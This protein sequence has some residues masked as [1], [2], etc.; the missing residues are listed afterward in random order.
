M[1][2]HKLCSIKCRASALAVSAVLLITNMPLPAIAEAYPSD[3]KEI[4][5]FEELSK[6]IS[7]Q[8]VSLG[9]SIEDLNLP[10]TIGAVIQFDLEESKPEES[11]SEESKPE[12]SQTE[13][14]KPEEGQTEESKP[15][16]SQ[17]EES[18]PEEG[19]TEES[20]TEESQTE[21]SKPEEGQNEENKSE[22]SQPEESLAEESQPEEN[23]TENYL[24]ADNGNIFTAFQNNVSSSRYTVFSREESF[25]QLSATSSNAVF[26]EENA[27]N[28]VIDSTDGNDSPTTGESIIAVPVTWEA[29]PSYDSDTVGTYIFTAVLP[30]D[31][32]VAAGVTMPEITVTVSDGDTL[33][34]TQTVDNIEITLT[35]LAG[36][37]PADAVLRVEKIVETEKVAQIESAIQSELDASAPALMNEGGEETQTVLLET[38]TFDIK[39]MGR[40]ADGSDIELQP[41]I[42]ENVSASEAVIVSFQNIEAPAAGSSQTMEVYYIEDDLSTADR[43]KSEVN[44][45]GNE[46]VI[47]PE[48]F[49][50]YTLV[51]IADMTVVDSLPSSGN[52]SAN[53]I[54]R[55][56][57]NT[58]RTGAG[59]SVQGTASSPTVIYIA[60]GVTLAVTGG[61]GSGSSGGTAGI[62]LPSGKTLYVTGPGSL[63]LRGGSGANGRAGYSGGAASS[64]NA[65]GSGGSGGYGGGGGGD[66]SGC[67]CLI[68]IAVVV[69]LVLIAMGS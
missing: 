6:D 24:V 44:P 4:I 34:L 53:T 63:T 27:D 18:K 35:A 32:S 14:S 58:T 49:S 40:D 45:D 64:D 67:G 5:S 52:L 54:Y 1:K 29:F 38:V 42:P 68:A 2:Q 20:K 15:E 61:S 62:Y 59:L 39:V 36:V 48:H 8:Q 3:G 13:E 9:T 41:L 23:K 51:R 7:Q 37:F 11:Q 69:V 30:D 47:N 31:Y 12:E 66:G 56:R 19:Q 55:V 26:A 17:P 28:T 43:I 60:S 25:R 46:I 33:N 10:M 50:Y 65:P 16:E 57:G 22:G 21:E